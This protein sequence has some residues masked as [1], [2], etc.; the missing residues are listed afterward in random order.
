MNQSTA[1][2]ANPSNSRTLL[3]LYLLAALGPFTVDL[4]LPALP[5][6]QDDLTATTVAAQLTLT[7]ATIGVALGQLIVGNWSDAA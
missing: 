4:Y 6:L 1:P 3:V 2:L 5:A 7:A